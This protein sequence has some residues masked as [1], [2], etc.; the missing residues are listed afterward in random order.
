MRASDIL[1]KTKKENTD[2][3]S[4][5]YD[6]INRTGLI[7]QISSGIYS[8]SP[9]GH[10]VLKNISN[11]VEDEMDK[12]GALQVSMPI[13]QPSEL[14][15]ES[16]RWNLYGDEMFKLKDRDGREFCLGPTH[17][18]VVSD[19]A[20]HFI[21]SYKDMPITIYQIG[22]KFRDELRPRQGLVRGKE[23]LM[24]DA[25]SFDIDEKGCDVSYQ[26]M[27]DAYFKIF[28]RLG[29]EFICMTADSGEIGGVGSEEIIALS[30]WGEDKFVLDGNIY[31]KYDE[32]DNEKE[33]SR[34]I[35]IGHIFK[36]G[37]KYS[38]S[39]KVFFNDKDGKL[40]P[41]LM[42]CYGIGI[43]R[44]ISAIVDQNN[45]QRGI[46]WPKEVSPFSLEIIALGDSP[47]VKNLSNEVHDSL[48]KEGTEALL[49]D[50]DK[51]PGVKFKDADLIGIPNRIIIGEK[52]LALG[53]VEY[54]D[55]VS[56]EKRSIKADVFEISKFLKTENEGIKTTSQ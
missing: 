16:G 11:I 54:E 17:E 48:K 13:V 12:A 53:E 6:L 50:R 31:R 14:W 25:Y 2:I 52:A 15:K 23:F 42:G 24:K 34:G 22:R 20:R 30:K 43:S 3:S 51:K 18:E 27:R 55:R 10:R 39:M 32:K 26:K 44:L 46:I 9:L 29:L 28:N 37:T 33:I 1:L 47:E 8:F 45:D 49:D 4:P 19:F 41:S 36:L 7:Y 38:E 35:E 5:G 56:R 21:E 40:K